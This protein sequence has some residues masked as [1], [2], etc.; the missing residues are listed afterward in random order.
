[1]PAKL[2]IRFDSFVPVDLM[3]ELKDYV[4]K[5]EEY[6]IQAE[7][8]DAGDARVRRK[9]DA[10]IKKL[11]TLIEYYTKLINLSKI[12]YHR[13]KEGESGAGGEY[14]ARLVKKGK[15]EFLELWP[16]P[17]RRRKKKK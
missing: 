1:M 12:T 6:K 13:L 3:R 4:E 15:S 16:K 2:K 8:E 14:H 11:D 10:V 9:L 7:S 17:Q 5:R